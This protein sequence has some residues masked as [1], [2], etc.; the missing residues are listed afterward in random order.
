MRYDILSTEPDGYD[1]HKLPLP[2]SCD[3]CDNEALYAAHGKQYCA[4]CWQ[5]RRNTL[6]ACSL[7][8]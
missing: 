5:N 1:W 8:G 7:P 6:L 4:T 2:F 3:I